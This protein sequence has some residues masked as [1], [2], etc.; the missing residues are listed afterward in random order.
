MSYAPVR[1]SGFTIVSSVAL[2]KDVTPLAHSDFQSM[3]DQIV[4]LPVFT[5][6][7]NEESESAA[8][9]TGLIAEHSPTSLL[10]ADGKAVD[11]YDFVS[12]NAGATK[13]LAALVSSL[14]D[15]NAALK[16]RLEALERRLSG[17]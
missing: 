5:Y 14:K 11:L 7:Y 10:S 9:H 1:A 8:V 6:R 4:G 12:V 2:K 13:A 15:E 16:Q 17:N 3:L